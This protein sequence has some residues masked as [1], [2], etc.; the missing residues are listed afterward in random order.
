MISRKRKGSADATDPRRAQ[1]ARGSASEDSREK[2]APSDPRPHPQTDTAPAPP[3]V[4]PTALLALLDFTLL[5][6]HAAIASRFD[7]IADALLHR[8]RLR[9]ARADG[10]GT[11]VCTDY[12]ILEL[13]FY[14]YMP[15]LHEDPFTHGSDEQRQSGR[16]CASSIFANGTS[17]HLRHAHHVDCT[18]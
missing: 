18:W 15:R 2:D 1:R 13:E 14:L 12:E 7:A 8:F 9:I 3:C 16:W 10:A 17:F 11:V 5:T 6:T 4:T